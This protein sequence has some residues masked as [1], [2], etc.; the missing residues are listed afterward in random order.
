MSAAENE[1]RESRGRPPDFPWKNQS[2]QGTDTNEMNEH[3]SEDSSI[4]PGDFSPW[5]SEEEEE[6]ES[7]LAARLLPADDLESGPDDTE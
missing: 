7:D 5:W 6:D 4:A 3:D 2:L 1:I